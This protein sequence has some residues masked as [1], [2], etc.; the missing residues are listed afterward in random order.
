[1]NTND[2]RIRESACRIW[3][4]A[5]RPEG[6]DLEFWC[7]AEQKIRVDAEGKPSVMRAMLSRNLTMPWRNSLKS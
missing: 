4:T 3:E 6:R 5:G 1:M 2:A 7:Q